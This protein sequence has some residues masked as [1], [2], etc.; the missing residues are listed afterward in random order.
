MSYF[1]KHLTQASCRLGLSPLLCEVLIT[2]LH[3]ML[4]KDNAMPSVFWINS[5]SWY[6]SNQSST[7]DV[8]KKDIYEV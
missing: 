1:Q 2:I 8:G 6:P 4:R 5:V 7:A 3:D